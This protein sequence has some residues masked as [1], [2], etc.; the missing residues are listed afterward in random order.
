MEDDV[1]L[2]KMVYPLKEI[3][4]INGFPW[5]NSNYDALD[6]TITHDLP[7]YYFCSKYEQGR[8]KMITATNTDKNGEIKP[9][10]K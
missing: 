10:L 3:I 2:L 8:E 7:V 4:V 1:L 5:G 9:S 6:T